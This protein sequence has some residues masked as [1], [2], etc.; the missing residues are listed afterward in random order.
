MEEETCERC[1][2]IVTHGCIGIGSLYEINNKMGKRVKVCGKCID[3]VRTENIENN[4]QPKLGDI[5]C[6][7]GYYGSTNKTLLLGGTDLETLKKDNEQLL[8]G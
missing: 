1:G 5:R 6:D 4:T 2:I 7:S 3:A 8:E